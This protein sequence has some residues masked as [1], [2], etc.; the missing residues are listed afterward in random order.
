MVGMTFCA[1]GWWG[2][3]LYVEDEC[4]LPN[5][6]GCSH[7]GFS[8]GGGTGKRC[9]AIAPF[10]PRRLAGNWVVR[11]RATRFNRGMCCHV[12]VLIRVPS[13]SLSLSHR[14]LPERSPH[15]SQKCHF[16]PLLLGA[17]AKDKNCH[18]GLGKSPGRGAYPVTSPCHAWVSRSHC[19]ACQGELERRGNSPAQGGFPKDTPKKTSIARH[20]C[21]MGDPAGAAVLNCAARYNRN[22][23]RELKFSLTRQRDGET[24]QLPIPPIPPRPRCQLFFES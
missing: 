2:G 1:C 20:F 4:N 5:L 3:W 22:L 7:G 16:V 14:A 9:E 10:N 8:H 13:S 17:Y 11:V 23:K 21:I 15:H 18:I 12:G 19:M 24:A 6:D